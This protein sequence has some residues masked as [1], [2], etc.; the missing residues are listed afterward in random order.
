[1]ALWFG[2]SGTFDFLD[3][4]ADESVDR[5]FSM[6]DD[7][8]QFRHIPM[9]TYIGTHF[10]TN[11]NVCMYDIIRESPYN[12]QEI[13]LGKIFQSQRPLS[14]PSSSCRTQGVPVMSI[15]SVTSVDLTTR[16]G[17]CCCWVEEFLSIIATASS[18]TKPEPCR[19]GH[20]LLS[21]LDGYAKL[22]P[23]GRKSL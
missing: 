1:V 14:S 6:Y 16:L 20:E 23:L 21:C 7:T 18:S 5:L 3:Y 8:Y 19:A 22:A 17:C 13:V 10:D 15:K 9:G 12:Y 4:R 11:A 2:P